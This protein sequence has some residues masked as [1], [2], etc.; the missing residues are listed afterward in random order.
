MELLKREEK[1]AE[2]VFNKARVRLISSVDG[3]IP[4]IGFKVV[5]DADYLDI[6]ISDKIIRISHEDSDDLFVLAKAAA[7]MVIVNSMDDVRN[8]IK[9]I[10][11]YIA[12]RL[13]TSQ[14]TVHQIIKAMEISECFYLKDTE[15]VALIRY[16]KDDKSE[17]NFDNINK[18]AD[19]MCNALRYLD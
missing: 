7:D 13:K 2:D 11:L 12:C 6:I 8:A 5:G 3:M 9:L 4:A 14:L 16:V 17:E 1:I 18:L 10:N 19:Y 15:S